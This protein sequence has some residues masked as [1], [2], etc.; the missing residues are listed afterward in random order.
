MKQ[1]TY[2]LILVLAF[3]CKKAN[4]RKCFKSYGENSEIEYALDSVQEFKLY[5]NIKYR[6]Y[7][8]TLRKVVVRGGNNLLDLINVTSESY[9]TQ[10]NNQN[11]CNFLRDNDKLMEV[12]IHYPYYH[13][14]YAEPTDSMVFV[15]TL[16]GD[17]TNIEVRNGGG[18]L[19]LSVDM[20]HISLVVSYGTGSYIVDGRSKYANLAV[21]NL[22]FGNA[23]N[24]DSK[25]LRIYQASNNDILVNTDSADVD[26]LFGGNGDVRFIGE[27]N[28]L[29]IEG[30]GDGE[31]I[32]Y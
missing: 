24:L 30:F 23:L 13:K 26:V 12:D 7:Q 16:R 32:T 25:F 4:E 20:N 15:D 18:V 9:I 21:Q 17:Y 2:I 11:N 3:S 28:S 22:G 6:F 29:D 5:K 31:V 19:K 14:I 1:F 10:I 27:A 8:D